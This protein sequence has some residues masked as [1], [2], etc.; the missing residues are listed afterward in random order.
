MRPRSGKS[1]PP[2]AR[3]FPRRR[4]PFVEGAKRLA[5]RVPLLGG[6]DGGRPRRDVVLGGRGRG[7]AGGRGRGERHAGPADGAVREGPRQDHVGGAPRR[8]GRRGRGAAAR[9]APRPRLPRRDERRLLRRRRRRADGGRR[10]GPP[11][12]AGPGL[13]AAVDHGVARA[14]AVR[15]AGH[16]R[17]VDAGAHPGADAVGA[18]AARG[19]VAPVRRPAGQA[20]RVVRP[21]PRHA[22]RG[23]GRGDARRVVRERAARVLPGSDG[24]RRHRLPAALPP[25]ELDVLRADAQHVRVPEVRGGAAGRPAAQGPPAAPGLRARQI[26]PRRRGALPPRQAAA[27]QAQEGRRR[28]AQG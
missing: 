17:R 23:P 28:R 14:D 7:D 12:G 3:V 20:R 5:T 6:R 22:P 11:G 8:V 10:L 25:R 27:D 1:P 19:G 4:E 16:G 9:A 15:H 2:R 21:D 24:V 18:A 26:P 13:P